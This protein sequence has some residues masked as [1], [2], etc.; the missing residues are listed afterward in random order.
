MKINEIKKKNP[1]HKN[2]LADLKTS[3]E[4]FAP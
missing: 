2:Q 1:Q 3:D 4:E